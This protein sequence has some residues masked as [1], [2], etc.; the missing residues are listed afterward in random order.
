VGYQR[1]IT[2]KNIFVAQLSVNEL[3]L[4]VDSNFSEISK[5]NNKIKLEIK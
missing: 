3:N 1:I 5:E 4:I 2:I